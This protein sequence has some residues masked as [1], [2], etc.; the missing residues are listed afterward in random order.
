M[1]QLLI[2]HPI[3]S[4]KKSDKKKDFACGLAQAMLMETCKDLFLDSD[5]NLNFYAS[6]LCGKNEFTH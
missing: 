3:C 4:F 6:S 5:Q 1:K 2:I